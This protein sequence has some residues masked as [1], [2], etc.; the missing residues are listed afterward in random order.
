MLTSSGVIKERRPDRNV[1]YYLISTCGFFSGILGKTYL[2]RILVH[3]G[4]YTQNWT[5]CNVVLPWYIE[6]TL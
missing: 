4:E 3:N 2:I 1:K 6:T 5:Q